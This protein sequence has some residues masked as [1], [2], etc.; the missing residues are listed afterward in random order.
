MTVER[1]KMF[2]RMNESWTPGPAYGCSGTN[3]AYKVTSDALCGY[4]YRESAVDHESD[5]LNE[6]FLPLDPHMN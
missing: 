4:I 6:A 5:R 2:S 3:G 1:L